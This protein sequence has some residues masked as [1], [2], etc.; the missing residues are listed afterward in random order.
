MVNIA[1][2]LLDGRGRIAVWGLGYIGLSTAAYFAKH[3]VSSIGIDINDKVVATIN[4]G[5]SPVKGLE[6]WLGFRIKPLIDQGL[7]KATTD[8][9]KAKDCLVHFIAV[10]TERFD[11]PW[12]EGLKD[13]VN[14]IAEINP[15]A[16][17][18]V[19]STLAPGTTDK[20]I[21]PKL[22]NV[23]IAPRRDWFT[24][25]YSKN[26]ENL[27]RIIGGNSK[28]V[29]RETRKILSIVCKKIYV[30]SD[31]R[32]AEM[33][34]SVEN[35]LR[36]IHVVAVQQL[37]WAYPNLDINEILYLAGTKWNIP[38]LYVS[39]RSSGYC[40]PLSTRYVLNGAEFPDEL[41]ILKESVKQDETN[42][43][44]FVDRLCDRFAWGT[45]VGILSL[46]YLGDIKV[47]ILSPTIFLVPELRRRGFHVAVHDPY[48]DDEYIAERVGC[49]ALK[50]PDDLTK[51]DLIIVVASHRMY[52]DI[53][54][55][56]LSNYLRTG[57]VIIDN[58]GTWERYKTDFESHGITYRRVGSKGWL[59]F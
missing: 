20:I 26:L 7:I 8:Y 3:G 52:R 58:H 48:Y 11:A 54:F 1:E 32:H 57:Q 9:T 16:L 21:L 38:S 37:A 22:K 15:D 28:E 44:R 53:E 30:A 42:I 12:F 55:A 43:Y 51:F 59:D 29:S 24:L 31:H 4:K 23:A 35:M 34:K 2:K 10:N 25:E 33:V 18:I 50:F 45:K 46:C 36:H 56:E 17:V 39:L 6:R 19:E 49:D 47:D 14:K 40:V 41:K 27:P 13:V 5:R